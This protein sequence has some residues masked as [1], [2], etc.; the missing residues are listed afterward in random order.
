M[1][2]SPAGMVTHND[3]PD[4]S[5]PVVQRREFFVISQKARNPNEVITGNLIINSCEVYTLF[6]TSSTHSFISP[7]CIQRLNLTPKKLD[8]DLSVAFLGH[9]I[10]NHEISVDPAKIEVIQSWEQPKLVT[11]VRSFLGFS[12]Y[13]RRFVEGFSRIATLL[14]LLT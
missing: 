4:K 3:V 14:T 9:V 8:F 2:L 11:E 1:K 10:S 12:G 7:T 5:K 13:Y 6:D